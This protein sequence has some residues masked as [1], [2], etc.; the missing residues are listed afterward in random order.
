VDGE[1]EKPCWKGPAEVIMGSLS[2]EKVSSGKR[3]PP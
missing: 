3:L 2:I 1:K